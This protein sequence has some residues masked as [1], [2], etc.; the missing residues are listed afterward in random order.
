MLAR[1]LHD[2]FRNA[3]SA[4]SEPARGTGS[5]R[6]VS[7]ANPE[8]ALWQRPERWFRSFGRIFHEKCGLVSIDCQP[9][10][11]WGAKLQLL[12]SDVSGACLASIN[13]MPHPR[14][15]GT[16]SQITQW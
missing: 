5:A 9:W 11:E 1:I 3:I 13:L 4:A 10:Y 6:P 7:E 16:L 15:S 2:G 8:E 14:P 12:P